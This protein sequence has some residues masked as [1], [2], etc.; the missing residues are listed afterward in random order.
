VLVELIF[1]PGEGV[2]YLDRLVEQRHVLALADS[3]GVIAVAIAAMAVLSTI[4][5]CI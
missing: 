5:S 3:R 2:P 1:E 4:T